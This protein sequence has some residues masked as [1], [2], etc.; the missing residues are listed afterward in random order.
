MSDS[1]PFQIRL[2]IL[3]L[4]KDIASENTQIKASFE[5]EQRSYDQVN[6]KTPS[7]KMPI[8]TT[9]DVLAEAAKLYA[10][11]TKKNH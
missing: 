6:N 5:R 1:Q 9:D 3:Q 2:A 10:F 11:I 7:D 8:Y 4:A